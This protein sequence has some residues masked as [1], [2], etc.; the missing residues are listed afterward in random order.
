MKDKNLH[1]SCKIYNG[2]CTCGVMCV[3][4]TVRNVE[5][6]HEQELQLS[7]HLFLNIGHSFNWSVLLS[8]P[9]SNRTRKILEAFFIA[10]MKSSLNEQF[11]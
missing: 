8:A 10:K 2:E 9:K 11:E 7:K 6:Q 5:V 4:E 3:G 1:P